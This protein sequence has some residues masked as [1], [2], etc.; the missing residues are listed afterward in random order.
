MTMGNLVDT[1]DA[2][3][4]EAAVLE[5]E[6]ATD[7]AGTAPAPLAAPVD[8]AQEWREAAHLGCGL[9]LSLYPELKPEWGADKLD[10]L[11]NALAKCAERYGWTVGELFGHPLV[12]LAFATWPLAV[13]LAR[14]AKARAEQAKREQVRQAVAVPAQPDGAVTDRPGNLGSPNGA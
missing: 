7:A 11:G 12:G 6:T 13:P 10:N 2:I 8:P 9:V 1:L 3:V 14:I 5:Q 4:A